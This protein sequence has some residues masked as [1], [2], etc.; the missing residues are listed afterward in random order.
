[1]PRL[2]ALAV[3][4][5]SSSLRRGM[6][7]HELGR[8]HQDLVA[9]GATCELWIDGSFL[10][11]KPEP[12]DI[13][14][15]FWAYATDMQQLPPS[16]S[17]ALI[18]ELN[19]GKRYSPYLDTYINFRFP[20]GD[21]RSPADRSRYWAELWGRGW[22]DHLTGYAVVRIGESHVGLQLLS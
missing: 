6:L 15:L 13:D 17:T 8:L 1:M 11:E 5:F 9:I 21:P 7:F 2:E 10:T 22:D 19:G 18:S 12:D 20:E 4:P 3:S 14:V 16:I